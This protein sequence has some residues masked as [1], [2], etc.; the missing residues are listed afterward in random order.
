M[1]PLKFLQAFRNMRITT[2]A[3]ALGK[4]LANIEGMC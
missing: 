1:W 4:Y 3:W 2:A